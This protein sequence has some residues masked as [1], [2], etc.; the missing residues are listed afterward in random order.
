MSRYAQVVVDLSA[1]AVDRLYSYTV[2]EG[3]AVSPGQLV[4]VP[5]GPRRLEGFVVSLD[6]TCDL[7]PEKVKTVIRPVRADPVILPD[8]LE[9]AEWMHLHYLCN[10]VD[11]L[12]LMIP[13]EMRGGRVHERTVRYARIALEGSALQAFREA[14][15][16]A[17]KQLQVLS[18]LE[19]GPVQTSRLDAAA[20][21]ALVKKGAVIFEEDVV[22]RMPRVLSGNVQTPDPELMPGQKKALDRL[23]AAM[24]SGG[25]RF[26]LHGVT[27]SGKTEVYIRTIR[28]A[29]QMGK[30]A[31]VLV[32][33][34][35]LTPQMV[36]WLHGRFGSEAA[37]LHSALSAGERYDEWQRIRYGRARVVIGARS[38]VFAPLENIGII[39]V[40]EEHET[41]YQSDRR[42]RYDAREVAWKRAQQHGAVLLLGSATPSI[43][44]YMRVMPG[45]RPENRLELIEL[46]TRVHNRPLPQVEVVDMRG[47]T[48]RGNQSLF[49]GRLYAELRR[50]L[51]EGHQAM[52]FIN[53]RGHSTF[54]SCRSCGYVVRCDQC[55]V[56]MTWHQAENALRCHYCGKTMPLPKRCPQ[57]AS[58]YIKLYGA[59]TQKVQEEVQRLLPDARIAR[60]DVDTTREKDAHLRIL[61]RFREGDANVLVGTQMIAKGLDFPNVALVGVVAA[62][63]SLNLPD[64]RSVERTFQLITQVAGRAGRGDIPG[65]VIVQT[66]EPD[67][68]GIRC[69][70]EQDY[71]A[72][73]TRESAFRRTALYPPYS[74]IARIVYC[75]EDESQARET[76]QADE[77]RLS[78]Y[79][80]EHPDPSGRMMRPVAQEAPV[81][82][83]RGEVRWQLLIRLYFKADIESITREMQALADAA[84]QGV[85]AELEINPNNLV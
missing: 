21:G 83:I 72:F 58:G 79:L 50:C 18:T 41:T 81:R 71:R 57:C 31:I 23:T 77:R 30:T 2:P 67:H 25:G 56:S 43:S 62:D 46:R 53:R 65:R 66:Y 80:A 4:L 37:V 33:E 8:L 7:P 29:L 12:R 1:E 68:Y 52:L 27:G 63:L 61:R 19:N 70:A 11:A 45:V 39:V 32:P 76:A 9:L 3:M 85:R 55:D 51:D 10:L 60:M 13:A 24:E 49:S 35:A 36:S 22:R 34:I 74:V 20:L 16:R 40:D 54:V 14:N 17:P 82:Q 38:A 26:L 6:N 69:A 59:G 42:P 5:F 15:K 47:E 28:K 64:F 78:A 73:Y 75:S 48:E 84:P 44:T